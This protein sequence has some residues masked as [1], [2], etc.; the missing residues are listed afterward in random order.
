[1]TGFQRNGL[2][3]AFSASSASHA[4]D[5]RLAICGTLTSTAVAGG[6]IFDSVWLL[7]FLLLLLFLGDWLS[8]GTDDILLFLPVVVVVLAMLCLR[9]RVDFELLIEVDLLVCFTGAPAAMADG[10]RGDSGDLG[11]GGGIDCRLN[12]T[13]LKSKDLSLRALGME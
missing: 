2:S 10:E 12:G 11:T 6:D 8:E 3:S 13:W 7:A 9:A 1:M 4:I 5:G